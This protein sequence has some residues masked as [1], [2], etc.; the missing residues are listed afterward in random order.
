MNHG[1]ALIDCRHCIVRG[2][3]IEG[4]HNQSEDVWLESPT[5]DA[6]YPV[7]AENIFD[8]ETLG[9]VDYL[10]GGNNVEV[11][12]ANA[13]AVSA[14]AQ[15]NSRQLAANS[16][17]TSGAWRKGDIVWNRTPSA[18]GAPLGWVCSAT[19]GVTSFQCTSWRAFSVLP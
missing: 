17:P 19:A 18:A 8:S 2:N 1:V 7:I 9:P 16:Y 3:T 10:G 4:N 15:H 12:F 14:Y 6:R 13:S 11:K 5:R